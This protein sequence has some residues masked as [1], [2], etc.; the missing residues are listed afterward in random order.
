MP[1]DRPNPTA[2]LAVM[3]L[4]LLV[5]M[6]VSCHHGGCLRSR[7]RVKGRV[8]DSG[9]QPEQ[10]LPTEVWAVCAIVAAALQG[11]RPAGD[12]LADAAY[13]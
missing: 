8:A 6:G 2:P 9:R 3:V 10:Q 13:R 11:A 4:P 5:G 1:V 7:P 12:A